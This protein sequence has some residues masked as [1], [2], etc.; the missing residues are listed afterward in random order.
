MRGLLKE[1]SQRF[2][3]VILDTPPV[4]LIPDARLMAD[5]VDG[6]IFVIGAKSTGY[7]FVQKAI[8]EIGRDRIFG[9]VLNRVD[10]EVALPSGYYQ[11]YYN[12]TSAAPTG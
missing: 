1:A 8:E 7:P 2:D 4:G 3:W 12:R 9:T 10:D 6:V 11:Q 5:L